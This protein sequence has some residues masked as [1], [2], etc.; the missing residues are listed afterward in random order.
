[1]VKLD[2][3]GSRASKVLHSLRDNTVPTEIPPT[4]SSILQHTVRNTYTDK[5]TNMKRTNVSDRQREFTG[6]HGQQSPSP[7]PIVMP[8]WEHLTPEKTSGIT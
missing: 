5:M 4:L 8:T 1:M 3:K 7:A 6:V 2:R